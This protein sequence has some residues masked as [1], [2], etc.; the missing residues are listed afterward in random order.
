M[1]SS[2]KI[3]RSDHVASIALPPGRIAQ[4]LG[5][6]HRSDVLIRIGLCMI[7]AI[8]M[9]MIT[10]GWA[11]PFGYRTG[12]TP[13]RDID[14]RVAFS[15]I[16]PEGTRRLR[17]EKRSE[18]MCVY[19]QDDQ[20]LRE[21]QSALK[22]GVFQVLAANSHDE[23]NKEIWNQFLS[24]EDKKPDLDDK[25]VF[26]HVRAALAGDLDLTKFTKAV[27]RAFQQFEETGLIDK[28]QH[29][30]EDGSQ[31]SLKVHPV[32]KPSVVKR[33]EVKDVRIAEV[34]ADLKRR[35]AD[36]FSQ[37][38][39]A[40]E[41]GEELAQL[42]HNWCFN[43]GLPSTLKLDR[44]ATRGEYTAELDQVVAQNLFAPGDKLVVGGATITAE[45]LEVLRAERVAIVAKMSPLDKLGL[46]L[47]SLGMYV[48]LFVLCGVFVYHHRPGIIVNLR[49]LTTLLA[50]VVVTITLARLCTGEL[51]Q[52]E[53]VPI[54]LFGMTV[55]IAY[56]RDLAIILSAALSLVICVALGLGLAEFV[57]MVATGSAANLLLNRVR[58]RTKL[59][60]VGLGA[61]VVAIVTTIG[62]GTLVGEPLG[63][64]SGTGFPALDGW[65]SPRTTFLIH[66][67][68]GAIWHGFCTLLAALIMT[69]L[70]PCIERLFDVQTD[71]SL[72]ELGD[73]AHPLLQE[74]ARRAPGTYNHSINV[75]SLAEVAAE[76]IG[77][78]GLLVRVGA[79]FHDIGK[80]FKPGYFVENQGR[81]V[82]RHES[83][84]P[85]MSTLVIIAHVKD[86]AD[87]ARQNRLPRSIIDFIE[88]HHGTTLVE[89]FY[90][91]AARQSE[92]NPDKESVE[93]SSYRYPGPKP[94]SRE[95]GVLMIADAVESASRTLVD[96]TP[97]RIENL[98][99]DIAMKKLLDGQFDACGITLLE[100]SC[101]RD[102]LVKSL[103]AAYHAR[104][105]YPDQQTA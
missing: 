36:E 65:R 11:P 14:A 97:A 29:P 57:L 89:Y 58:S 87:L 72:L 59:S 80:M 92:E 95:A 50:T 45:K 75:A 21:L 105:K 90:R 33:V 73:A 28:L 81:D 38:G 9:W 88:Q 17:E 101:I 82:N 63:S 3:T 35:L 69:G 34:S 56:S 31:I 24:R 7:A 79:Y 15:I 55:T 19:A 43:R 62:I 10:A 78:N 22:S 48:A 74:L 104:V 46:S 32:G 64:W 67:L 53:V 51:W 94:H 40:P 42:A 27:K 54:V 86:G 1:S 68:A 71:I 100:L 93:E 23:L 13:L 84:L 77:A 25:A 85:A 30:P 39:F 102:S 4:V 70:L 8:L 5:N 12:Y 91:Q 99:E 52:A 98:V 26:A 44:E 6:L 49:S 83:L 20:P 47:S 66:L 76:S 96:P 37:A 18:V 16:D 61:A 103:T 41:H 60:Y 2:Q